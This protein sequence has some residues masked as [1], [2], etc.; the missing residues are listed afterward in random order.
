MK[1]LLAVIASLIQSA[2]RWIYDIHSRSHGEQS[3]S[4]NTKQPAKNDSAA[5]PPAEPTE[6][7]LPIIDNWLRFDRGATF[8]T[9]EFPLYTDVSFTGDMQQ[10]GPYIFLNLIAREERP[11]TVR[12]AMVLRYAEARE[13]KRPTFPKKSNTDLYH[14]GTLVDEVAALAA[15]LLGAR[16]AS[17]GL[18]RA[19][20]GGLTNDPMGR[21]IGWEQVPIPGSIRFSRD[22]AIVPSALGFRKMAL[23]AGLDGL[24]QLSKKQSVS[25]I[26]S[27][28]LFNDALWLC[29]QEPHLSWLML[30]SALEGAA[31]CWQQEKGSPVERLRIS[32]PDFSAA[33]EEQF[34]A[35]LLAR[36]AAEFSDSLG[37]TKKFVD[38]C[39]AHLPPAPE[40]RPREAFQID[41]T[42]EFWQRAL[43]QIYQY[44]SKALHEGIPFPAPL[45]EPPMLFEGDSA[46]SERGTLG[47]ST[48]TL[49]GSWIAKD[50]PVNMNVF[51]QFTRSVLL[52][53]LSKLADPA[54]MAAEVE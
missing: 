47:L 40:P 20:G 27:A 25:L 45:S 46:H 39:L 28:N 30:V 26:R 7:H 43:R 16:C 14:G 41:W 49:G 53:W 22:S 44:R 2:R 23:L 54:A 29:E 15:L 35:D 34:G 1:G 19:F 42:P 9:L 38:F 5:P 13:G 10:S 17:G 52:N 36:V 12:P 24:P 4:S 51:V 37:V 8:S 21:P 3:M 33:I 31:V 18:S 32:K 6:D 50:L 11:G 48:N